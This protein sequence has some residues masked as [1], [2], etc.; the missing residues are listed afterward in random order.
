MS[1]IHRRKIRDCRTYHSMVAELDL[2][3][4]LVDII[5]LLPEKEQR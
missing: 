3:A 1:N 2:E 5:P 4:P